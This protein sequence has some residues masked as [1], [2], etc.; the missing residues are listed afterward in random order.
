M[1]FIIDLLINLAQEL[2]EDLARD[3]RYGGRVVGAAPSQPGEPANDNVQV[4]VLFVP[5]PNLSSIKGKWLKFHIYFQISYKMSLW[6]KLILNNARERLENS[7]SL[8]KLTQHRS[9][10]IGFLT[11]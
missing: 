4:E 10:T 6:L 11:K 5:C 9:I 3:E 2:R 7:S 8:A 1:P